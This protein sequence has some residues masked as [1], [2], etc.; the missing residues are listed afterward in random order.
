MLCFFARTIQ[1]AGTGLL[2]TSGKIETCIIYKAFAE[3]LLQFPDM[4]NKII[5]YLESGAGEKII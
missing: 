2:C 1:G 4:S 3:L 5:A